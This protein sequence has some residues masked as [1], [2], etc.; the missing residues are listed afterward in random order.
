MVWTDAQIKE[1]V[2]TN[3]TAGTDSISGY[4]DGAN[5]I[6]GLDGNDT[7]SGGA[8]SDLLDGGNG[9]DA[10]HGKAGNDTLLG[11]AGND[12]INGNA[13]DDVIVGGVGNDTLYGGD[14][15]SGTGEGNDT[16][17]FSKGDGQDSVSDYDTTAGN[18]DIIEFTDVKSSEVTGLNRVVYDLVLS[19][20]VNDQ[21]SIRNYFHPDP[22]YA[23]GSRIEQFKFS[24]GVVWTD[25]Q[26]KA[27]VVTNGTSIND[28]ISGDNSST[29]R[30]YGFDGNDSLYGGAL[31]DL[32]D[33]G[34]GADNLVGYAGDDT[35]VV[36][37]VGDVVSENAD[38]G[39]DTVRSSIT[40]VL[41][42]NVENLTLTG[43]TAIYG[44][45]NA[46]DN[47]LTGNSSANTL[48][49][50]LGNDTLD[51]GAGADRLVGGA[52]NDVYIVDN[53]ADVVTENADEGA[54]TVQSA[55]TTTL[56]ANI[57]NLTLT[58]AAAINGT[59]NAL[60]NVLIGNAAAN[61]LTGGAGNDTYYVSTG[62]TVTESS[63]E[64]T[65]R[66]IS[67]VAWTLGANLENLTLTGT[68]AINGTGNTLNN[69]LIG[70]SASNTLNGGAGADSMSGGAGDDLYVIDNVGDV[71]AEN[72]SEGTDL[73]Q[74]SITYTLSAHI[75]NLTLTGS[76]AVNGTGN[77][78]DN[79]LTGNS[80]VNTLT[81]GAGNDTLNGGVGADKL[82]GGIGNDIY[83]VD[84]AK[85]VVMENVGEGIDTVRSSVTNKMAANIEALF[86]TGTSAINGTGNAW[87]NLVVGNSANN[88]LNGAGG[89]DL[90]QGGAGVDT[91]TDTSGNN[92]FDGG[93]GADSITAGIGSDFIIGGTGN[94][95]IT[96]GTGADVIAFNRGDGMDVIKASTG[97]DNTLSLGNGIKYADLLFKKS[98]NDLILVT[99]VNE[100]L[101]FKDWYANTN[102]RSV[103]NLQMV[104]EG[105]S[106]YDASSSSAINNQKIEQF[107]F[108]GL[109]TA[110]DQ[111]R[112]ANPN[113]TS[114]AL[115]NALNN[116]HL[117][118]SDTAA[119][120]GD[121]AYQYAK[122]GNLAN[123]SMTPAQSLLAS[124]QF[125]V[126]SQNLQ[127]ASGLQDLSPRL[128]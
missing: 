79:V 13:G 36:D 73:V 56:G 119:M 9:D 115:S 29:N 122:N 50:G 26:I 92:L 16:Y 72:A 77:A 3:G 120:G 19:Y 24:D 91:L 82:I 107:N 21:V 52:G 48:T 11:G 45:G 34:I 53:A 99:G 43:A 111:A 60:D 70:N 110:F 61:V 40:Y 57:E 25:A 100:Q 15:W 12:T 62:D 31:S 10:L 85:D 7:L 102:N 65:D 95:T 124:S 8:L 30:L 32:L 125:G 5:R 76:S 121:L 38:Q 113:L 90:L 123:L 86:L 78:L 88:I 87:D 126:T 41:G 6:Y 51:G 84:N 89:Y 2:I 18:N 93:I 67:D 39:I 103:A 55:V 68:T 14:Y 44:T 47:V 97:K 23:A 116:F 22:T 104:I 69:I 127:T 80:A 4:S 66:V 54:D 106:D 17:R 71:V 96:T 42:S 128:M 94:D 59:G 37:N 33:G 64:G 28:S 1:L 46:L 109:V 35:Y 81:G 112:T 101:S 27:Q 118:A 108:D 75:E 20:G 117:R 105:T 74:S 83:I 63:S 58:G 49:G 98:S 114:W